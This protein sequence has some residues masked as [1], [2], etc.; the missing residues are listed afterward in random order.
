VAIGEDRYR[1]S[2]MGPAHSQRIAQAVA[3]ALGEDR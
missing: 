2:V 1:F 3:R